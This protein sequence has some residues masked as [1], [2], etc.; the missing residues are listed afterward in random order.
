MK[1]LSL[2]TEL[3][4]AGHSVNFIQRPDGGIRITGIDGRQFSSGGS[5]GNETA[6]RILEKGELSKSQRSQ[7]AEAG[8]LTVEA[9]KYTNKKIEKLTKREKK[10]LRKLNRIS[11]KRGG[12]RV[13]MKQARQSKIGQKGKTKELFRSLKNQIRHAMDIMYA[14][15]INTWRQWIEQDHPEL[16]KTIAFLRNPANSN[17][18]SETSIQTVRDLIYNNDNH[19]TNY[20]T[21]QLDQY[22]RDALEEGKSRIKKMI[23]GEL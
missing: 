2:V 14:K 10:E 21:E 17:Y 23:S 20:T 8:L 6:R 3:T 16:V 7:R 15:S 4:A 9:H 22:C 19:V 18:T 5:K 11:K 12:V 1:V 13:G